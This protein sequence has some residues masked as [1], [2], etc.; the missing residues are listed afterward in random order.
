MANELLKVSTAAWAC[1]EF[2]PGCP[3]IRL[4][5]SGK[6][7]TAAWACIEFLPIVAR[8][9]ESLPRRCLNSRLGLH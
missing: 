1:I 3:G 4:I 2:L 5:E 7:S 9:G 6:V 8:Y